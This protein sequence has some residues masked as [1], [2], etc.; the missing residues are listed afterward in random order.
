MTV[1]A[2]VALGLALLLLRSTL[3]PLLGLAALG[4]DL[5][6]PLVVF[7]GAR[8]RFAQGVVLTIVLGYLSDLLG[9]GPPGL[10][11][12]HYALAFTLAQLLS[13]RVAMHGLAIPALLVFAFDVAGGAV[14]SLLF[15]A[16][17]QPLPRPAGG[18]LLDAAITALFSLPL[19]PVLRALQR[20]TTREEKL[21]WVD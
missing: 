13:G 21:G 12:L 7:Y 14:L 17:G 1:G 8:G 10:Y 15:G 9:G 18:L 3:L 6:F 16:W 5:V 4:P 19:I 11:L 2:A 20:V